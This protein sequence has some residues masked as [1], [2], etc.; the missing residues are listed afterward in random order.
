[1]SAGRRFFPHLIETKSILKVVENAIKIVQL[2]ASD[3]KIK[4]ETDIPKKLEWPI[5]APLIEQAMVNL[6]SNAVKYSDPG[7]KIVIQVVEEQNQLSISVIDKGYGM[8]QKN[9]DRLFERFYRVDSGR[10]SKQGGTGLGLS[11]VKHIVQTH[12]GII[13]VESQEGVGSTFQIILPA[14]REEPVN[15]QD[16]SV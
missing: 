9:L 15:Q 16:S 2:Q 1:M 10:S 8:D 12:Q 6:L 5:N 13:K 4:V 7:K 3:K 14:H 11:I